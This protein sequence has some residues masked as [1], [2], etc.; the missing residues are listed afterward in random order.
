VQIV[1]LKN[2]QCGGDPHV[3]GDLVTVGDEVGRYMITVGSAREAT[4]AAVATSVNPRP[5]ADI[6][7]EML[8]AGSPLVSTA[9][10]GGRRPF[11][12]PEE[13]ADKKFREVAFWR[14]LFHQKGEQAFVEMRK[15]HDLKGKMEFFPEL[16]KE[17]GRGLDYGCGLMSVFEGSNLNVEGYDPLLEEYAKVY[18]HKGPVRYVTN[19]KGPYDFICCFNVIDHTPDPQT[20]V[21]EIMALL[22]PGGRLYFEVNFDPQLYAAHYMLFRDE[23]VEQYMGGFRKVRSQVT[24]AVEHPG[25]KYYEA[26]YIRP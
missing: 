20:I 19:P 1:M 17:K 4:P 25:I 12:D 26:L 18:R 11:V 6:R 13:V 22:K 3:I 5:A 23:Q 16:A 24:D 2:K 10:P 7:N 15:G 21:D 14:D 8:S 9:V